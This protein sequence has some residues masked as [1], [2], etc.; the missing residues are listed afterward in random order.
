MQEDTGS[1]CTIISEKMWRSIGQPKLTKYGKR[2][3]SYADDEF[4]VI[5]LLSCVISVKHLYIPVSVRVVRSSKSF[6]LLGR[7]VLMQLNEVHASF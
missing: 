7:D 2:L 5:G 3:T 6:G 1:S 4:K